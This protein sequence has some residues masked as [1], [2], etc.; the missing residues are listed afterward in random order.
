MANQ[1]A[2]VH[3]EEVVEQ[4]APELLGLLGPLEVVHQRVVLEAEAQLH[5]AEEG[6][7]LQVAQA[8]LACDGALGEA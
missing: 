6:H 5:V 3:L 4:A 1:P 7:V 2:L 8:P